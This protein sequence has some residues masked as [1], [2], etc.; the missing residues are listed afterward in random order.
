MRNIIMFIF[1]ISFLLSIVNADNYRDVNYFKTGNSIHWAPSDRVPG[2]SGSFSRKGFIFYALFGFQTQIGTTY[3]GYVSGSFFTAGS[4]FGYCIGRAYIGLGYEINYGLKDLW[5]L[6]CLFADIRI[7]ILKDSPFSPY[8]Y[9]RPGV[10]SSYHGPA[11]GG[12]FGI[13]YYFNKRMGFYVEGGYYG[14]RTKTYY[15]TYKF[16]L[17]HAV[18]VN[19]GI[20][21]ILF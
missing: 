5:L 18:G 15:Y 1:S 4:S 13:E 6:E 17:I 2:E 3:W 9:I 12:G 7:F 8:F 21:V 16:E 20:A 10:H 19:T 14:L 11:L